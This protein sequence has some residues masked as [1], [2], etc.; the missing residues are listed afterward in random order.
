MTYFQHSLIG[1]GKT[2]VESVLVMLLVICEAHTVFPSAKAIIHAESIRSPIF[3]EL[4]KIQTF[5]IF[6]AS[7][8]ISHACCVACLF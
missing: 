1:D 2:Q 6:H 8:C 5:M 7:L 3:V 4:S